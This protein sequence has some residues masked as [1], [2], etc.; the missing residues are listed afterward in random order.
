[1]RN[2]GMYMNAPQHAKSPEYYSQVGAQPDM[3][4]YM[5][6]FQHMMPT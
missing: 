2:V 3:D 6:S 4:Q 5:L 1:M